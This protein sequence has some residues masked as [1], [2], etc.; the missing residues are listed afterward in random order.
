MLCKNF[1]ESLCCSSTSLLKDLILALLYSLF[2][3]FLHFFINYFFSDSITRESVELKI[4][5]RFKERLKLSLDECAL[6]HTWDTHGHNYHNLF[7]IRCMLFA[8][9]VDLC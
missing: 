9:Q 2:P 8:I 7:L 1:E 6:T 5:L 4:A 3:A